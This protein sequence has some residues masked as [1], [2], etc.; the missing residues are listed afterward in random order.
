MS[1]CASFSTLLVADTTAHHLTFPLIGQLCNVFYIFLSHCAQK[2]AFSFNFFCNDRIEILYIGP[3]LMLDPWLHNFQVFL[4][5]S[6]YS[7]DSFSFHSFSIL[8]IE[9]EIKCGS[10]VCRF[11]CFVFFL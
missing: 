1:T 4:F 5:F 2:A 9:L 11:Q 6:S 7:L 8:P 10:K 3:A